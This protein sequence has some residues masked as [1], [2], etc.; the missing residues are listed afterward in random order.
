MSWIV[1]F[2]AE[3]HEEFETFPLRVRRDLM[4]AIGVLVEFGPNLG[5]PY[6][7]TLRGSGFANMKELRVNAGGGVW[8][9]AF[10]FDRNREAIVLAA[11]AKRGVNSRKFYRRL[12][13]LADQRFAEYLDGF[14]E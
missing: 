7:D 12:I 13:S 3:F 14:D 1:K 2:H 4:A 10:A 5:R 11:G 9:V 8:R 6:V